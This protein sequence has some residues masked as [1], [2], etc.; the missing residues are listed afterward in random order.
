MSR[1]PTPAAKNVDTVDRP[2]ASPTFVIHG[3]NRSAAMRRS[4]EDDEAMGAFPPNAEAFGLS[5]QHI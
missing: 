1:K 4:P 5:K 2:E 3:R